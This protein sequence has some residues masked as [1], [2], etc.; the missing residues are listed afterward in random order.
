MRNI[1][2][3]IVHCTATR[4]EW[5]EANATSAKVA[6]LKRWHCDPK[7]KG[8][9]WSDIGYHFVV[10]RNGAV[11]EGRPLARSGA[12]CRGRNANSIGVTLVGGFGSDADDQFDEHFTQDQADALVALLNRLSTEHKISKITGHH[13]YANKACPGFRMAQFKRDYMG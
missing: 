2:E 7:P 1:D 5:M 13:D 9:G 4:P 6:E 10:D 8:R 11:A 12:H 3:I